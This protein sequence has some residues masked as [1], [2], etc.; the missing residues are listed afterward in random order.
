M[1]GK[2]NSPIDHLFR[3]GQISAKQRGKLSAV[4]RD[5]KMKSKMA[6]F[7]GKG[8]RDEGGV[9]DMGERSVA[10]HDHIN[11]KQDLGTVARGSG[12]P[13]NFIKNPD[14][15]GPL[16]DEIDDRGHQKPDF[17][18]GAKVAKRGSSKKLRNQT[19]N[20]VP[21]A[22]GDWYSSGRHQDGQ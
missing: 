9:M 8:R 7:D 6:P 10:S 18:A 19:S 17:P 4:P 3:A 11:K 21:K 2:L 15:N 14:G 12:R 13:N 1:A 16:I 22:T 20:K 5:G